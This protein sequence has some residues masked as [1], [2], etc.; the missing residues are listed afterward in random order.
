MNRNDSGAVLITILLIVT[1]MATVAVAVLD[2]I[3][4]GVKRTEGMQAAAQAH[5][6]VLGAEMLASRALT[7]SVRLSTQKTDL[8]QPWATQSGQFLV[9]GG[10]IDARLADATACLNVNSLVTAE[11]IGTFIADETIQPYFLDVMKA[12]G[13]VDS[14][15]ERLLV[16][17]TDW[18]DTDTQAGPSGAEDFDYLI[19]TPPYRTANSM[20]TD[21]TTLRAIEAFTP[22]VFDLMAPLLCPHPTTEF[23]PIN[24]NTLDAEKGSLLL[25]ALLGPDV[26]PLDATNILS[27]RP[28]EGFSRIDDVWALDVLAG[29]DI[30]EDRRA[31]FGVKSRF[32]VLNARVI[33]GETDKAM[34]SLFE[35]QDN[36]R[37]RLISRQFGEDY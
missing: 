14:E 24:I 25:S 34:T 4:F 7:E 23:V 36:N 18:I 11:D 2:D 29:K 1:V 17:M 31:L 5:W 30:A 16:Q 21:I 33:Y 8:T 20:M 26:E 15:A 32:F 13:V 22:A 3:R 28:A 12:V 27:Q 10:F 35:V 19:A 6:Y 9:P 37:V